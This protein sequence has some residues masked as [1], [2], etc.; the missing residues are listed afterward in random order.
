ME[1]SSEIGLAAWCEAQTGY[2]QTQL[3]VVSGDASF[4]RYFRASD[5]QRSL[6]AVDCPP[7]KE[8]MRPFLLVADAYQAANIPV[9]LV[10]NVDLKQGYMLQTD[11]GH[12]VLLSKLQAQ[13]ARQY[14]DQ[15][16][17]ILPRIM[18]VTATAE[19]DLPRFDRALLDRELALFKDWLLMQHLDLDWDDR[20]DE[21]WSEFCELIVSNAFAQPQVGVHRDYHSRNL[22]VTPK[23]LG[24]IDFQDAVIG[25]ITYDAVS[26][27]R[28]CYIEWPDELVDELSQRLRSQLQEDGLLSADIEPEQWQRWFD[29]MG[30]Q[31]HTKAAGIFARLAH[32]DDKTGYLKDVPRTLGYLSKVS[33]R[34]PELS[35]Y[36]QWLT[37]RI[38]PKWENS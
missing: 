37:Q 31:R 30:L 14:Y 11:L 25:P 10:L 16:L 29:W 20:D 5:G 4:R 6:I 27:L 36:H 15:A 26:L 9:P 7:D 33:A 17:S 13:N 32:R 35:N 19:G 38:I 8:D 23:G 2:P 22:M 21:L 18:G 12:T 28:D 1:D 3:E 24:V 34:Y